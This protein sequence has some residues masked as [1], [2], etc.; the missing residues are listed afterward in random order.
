MSCCCFG[1]VKVVVIP[2]TLF[3]SACS[4]GSG[5]ER[6]QPPASARPG[7]AAGGA[8]EPGAATRPLGQHHVD[9]STQEEAHNRGQPHQEES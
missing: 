2:V 1:G 7:A 9:G 6:A 3:P 8:A 4:S 5:C